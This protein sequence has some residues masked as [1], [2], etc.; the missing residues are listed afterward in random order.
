MPSPVLTNLSNFADTPVGK[1]VLG[2]VGGAV[3]GTVVQILSFEMPRLGRLIVEDQYVSVGFYRQNG[4]G[5]RVPVAFEEDPS[6]ILLYARFDI[7]NGKRVDV[8]LRNVRL[9]V[10][11]G[12]RVKTVAMHPDTGGRFQVPPLPLL[13]AQ[14]SRV[15]QFHGNL[16]LEDPIDPRLGRATFRADY[17]ARRTLRRRLQIELSR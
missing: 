9:V 10:T 6:Q 11:D 12:T 4:L 13:P 3:A 1:V 16:P 7:H 15:L 14:Q 17:F 8:Q 2:M 5:D